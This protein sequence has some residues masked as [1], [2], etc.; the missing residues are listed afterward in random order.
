MSLVAKVVDVDD[1]VCSKGSYPHDIQGE[2]ILMLDNR[3][4]CPIPRTYSREEKMWILCT[5][6][7]LANIAIFSNLL[8]DYYQYRI[9]GKL[10]KVI[11]WIPYM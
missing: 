3:R 7:V 4:L 6:L 5:L 2:K 1:M 10:P 9:N 8:Y 11:K